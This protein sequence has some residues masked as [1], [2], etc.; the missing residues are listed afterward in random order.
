[1]QTSDTTSIDPIDA[2][3]D[4]LERALGLADVWNEPDYR[5]GP[6]SLPPPRRLTVETLPPYQTE[7]LHPSVKSAHTAATAWYRAITRREQPYWLT[8]FGTSGCGKTFLA[9]HIRSALRKKGIDCQLWNWGTS[10]DEIVSPD[11]HLMAHLIRLPVL[12]LDDIGTGYTTS[13]KAADLHASKLYE[14]LE[15]REKKFT[16]I[17][18]NLSPQ[19]I[20]DRLDCRISSRLFRPPHKI[21]DLSMADDFSFQLYRKNHKP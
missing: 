4:R 16:L 10:F 3:L 12:I 13:D 5:P 14:I 19:D 1:M 7:G 6:I 8:L 18:S 20:K 2:A 9:R 11:S 21:I 17:T 15:S